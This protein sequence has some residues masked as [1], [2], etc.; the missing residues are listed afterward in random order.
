MQGRLCIVQPTLQPH[1]T[2]SPLTGTP[3]LAFL[4]T[5][6]RTSPIEIYR[7]THAGFHSASTMTGL[8]PLS[9]TLSSL[10]LAS[11]G[12]WILYHTVTETKLLGG[13]TYKDMP[14]LSPAHQVAQSQRF[15]RAVLTP[16]CCSQTSC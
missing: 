15:F 4:R 14:S 10:G 3:A 2:R 5:S 7:R 6:P 13:V 1:C 16:L 8:I 12:A 11:I 9:T